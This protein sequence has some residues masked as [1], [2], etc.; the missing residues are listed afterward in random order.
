MI[1]LLE[2]AALKA[3]VHK[4]A[5]MEEHFA[6]VSEDATYMMHEV[7]NNGGL[8]S[9]LCIGSPTGGGHHNSRFDF[10][11]DILLW[12]VRILW[13]CILQTIANE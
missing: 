11:E 5:I 9:F 13:E 4:H 1:N 8:S 12:G 6:P 7:Q 10:D 2:S 3:G